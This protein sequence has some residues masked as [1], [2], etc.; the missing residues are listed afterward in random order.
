MIARTAVRALLILLIGLYLTD[1][2]PTIAIIL[3]YYALLF[4]LLAPLLRLPAAV[5][6]V[7][8]LAWLALAP[9]ASHALRAAHALQGP[10]PQVGLTA[11]LASPVDA[12][13]T[14]L[15]TGYYPVLSWFGYLLV[16]AAVGRLAIT[17]TA[18]A[19][20]VAG[21]GA[22]LV[23]AS[24]LVSA[25]LSSTAA[26]RTA[27]A[28][29]VATTGRSSEGPLYGT[30]PTTSW[31]WLALDVPHSGTPPAMLGTTGLALLVLGG[32]LLL[33]RTPVLWVLRP[34]AAAGS[35]TLSLYT[36]H[37]LADTYGL[38]D[39]PEATRWAVHAVTALVAASTVRAFW[40]R[41]PLEA[42]VAVVVDEAVGP[43]TPRSSPERA[44]HDT[45]P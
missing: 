11:V 44:A 14:L 9:V 41:G 26:A 34:L 37:V 7:G 1:L 19:A 23:L 30:T 28:D 5:L 13:V 22:T 36:V 27:L 2:G 8:G 38:P 4:V 6:G 25:T 35:M 21:A 20:A 43:A 16:G 29:S 39:L 24:S 10:G 40:D 45:P 32:C 15:L 3:Q 31:W 17:R 12:L 18:V 33:A 42:L